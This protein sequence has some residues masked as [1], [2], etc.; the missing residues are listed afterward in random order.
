MYLTTPPG[1]LPGGVS[2]DEFCDLL[3]K[4]LTKTEAAAL[5]VDT[6]TDAAGLA[7]L[8]KHLLPRLKQRDFALLLKD[9]VDLLKTTDADG[10]HLSDPA[11][12]KN[13]RGKLG[14]LSIGVSSPLER[15]AA[16]IFAESG[17]DYIAFDPTDNPD[18]CEAIIRWW[19][20]MMTVPS[21]VL[22]STPEE[23]SRFAKAG[24]DFIA[25]K[26]DIWQQPDPLAA[27]RDIAK[28]IG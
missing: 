22:T 11:Q 2:P 24:A 1:F 10:V 20:E 18:E 9:R 17:A 16:I 19:H 23:A 25:V 14:D 8:E 28:V 26:A 5:L 7:A 12:L 4:A 15:H 6:G 21:I 27:L 3:I 13:L